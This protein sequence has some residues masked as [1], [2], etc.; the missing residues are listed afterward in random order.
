MGFTLDWANALGS[1]GQPGGWLPALMGGGTPGG[2]N[3]TNEGQRLK[4]DSDLYMEAILGNQD[5]LEADVNA[6]QIGSTER[7][8]PVGPPPTKM[9]YNPMVPN[10][11]VDQYN[12]NKLAEWQASGTPGASVAA[13]TWQQAGTRDAAFTSM[14]P[15]SMGAAQAG[16]ASM[17]GANLDRSQIDAARAGQSS[18]V[19]SLQGTAAGQGPSIAQ[20]QLRQATNANINQQMAAAQS[21]HGSARLAALRNAQFAGAQTQQVANSQAAQL[22][23]QEIQAAQAN[24]GNVLGIQR[25]QD[26]TAATTQA[27]LNQQTG[28]INAGFQQQT[29]LANAGFD[30]TANLANAQFGQQAGQFNAAGVTA[31]DR[32]NA[33]AW[34]QAQRDYAGQMNT[35][36]LSIAN[37]NL[38]AQ[39]NTNQLNT[40]RSTSLGNL[41]YQGL[42]GKTGV[43]TTMYGGQQDQE[44]YMQEKNKG[45][46]TTV[47]DLVGGSMLGGAMGG[48][49]LG[50]LF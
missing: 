7:G 15:A 42:A 5:R 45:M 17:T 10:A 19:S 33:D 25:G 48:G 36:N 35:G 28:A 11:T 16:A 32:A 40:N 24:L 14:A 18:L 30:Q 22:R 49:G 26:V 47:T 27:G 4:S 39:Q 13:P 43:D 1:G 38:N 21:A 12:A 20:E 31:T 37:A 6:P 9:G 34:N 41:E 29:G 3:Q 23:A 50:G 44:K 8:A 2:I 46:L